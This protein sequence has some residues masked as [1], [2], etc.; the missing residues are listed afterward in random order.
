MGDKSFGIDL[1]ACNR[2]ALEVK[3]GSTW[4]RRFASS[5]AAATSSAA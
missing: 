4:A 2:L 3:A 5:L 1:Q